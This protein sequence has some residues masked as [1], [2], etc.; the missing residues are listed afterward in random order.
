MAFG[1]QREHLIN[2]EDVSSLTST[3]Y[4]EETIVRM[5]SGDSILVSRKVGEV[6]AV[7]ESGFD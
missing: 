1:H 5:K 4:G 7:L 6:Q 2:P 3:N